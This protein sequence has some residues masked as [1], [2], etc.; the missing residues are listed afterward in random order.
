MSA[1][2]PQNTARPGRA[3]SWPL[4][5][6]TLAAAVLLA[7]CEDRGSPLEPASKPELAS[8]TAAPAFAKLSTGGSV[9]CGIT[10][11]GR[12]YCWGSNNEGQIGDGGTG[13]RT[14]P[15][16]V[17]GG[18]VFR[19]IGAGAS[20]VCGVTTEN[21][22]YCW[23]DNQAGQLGDGTKITR[24]TPVA[25]G[26]SRRFVQVTAEQFHTCAVAASDRRAF[27]WGSN[28][29]GQLGD[30]TVTERLKPA[31]VAGGR[32]WRQVSPGAFFTCGITTGSVAYCWGWDLDGH[33]G[34]GPEMMTRL[35]PSPVAGGYSFAQINAGG[36]HVCAVTTDQRG[37]CWGRG[38]AGEIGDGKTLSRYTPR[39]VAGGLVLRRISAGSGFT[40]A[41]TTTS[42]A[43]CW[44]LNDFGQIGNGSSGPSVLKPVEVVGGHRFAQVSAGGGHACGR[45]EAGAAWCWGGNFS[46]ALG[47]GTTTNRASPTLVVGSM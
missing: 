32:A 21:R 26:G 13:I 22:L 34:D 42:R 11:A 31:A 15:T 5:M 17:T 47:D 35:T 41:E 40:C 16:P 46:G 27:C 38:T 37:F 14:T 12:A 30:G 23:G 43:Y 44:G 29:Y 33:L 6:F 36:S 2:V 4:P 24:R 45:T 20:H 9:T 3:G 39:A 19:E 1:C 10:A 25:I 28:I 7:S 8:A 18:L